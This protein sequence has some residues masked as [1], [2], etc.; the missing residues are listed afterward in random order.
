MTRN[1]Y[2]LVTNMRNSIINKYDNTDVDVLK[3]DFIFLYG[4]SEEQVDKLINGEKITSKNLNF[5]CTYIDF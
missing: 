1:Y 4:L 5:Y 2:V 3:D